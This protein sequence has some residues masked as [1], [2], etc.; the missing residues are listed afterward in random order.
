MTGTRFRASLTVAVILALHILPIEMLASNPLDQSAAARDQDDGWILDTSFGF[1]VRIALTS[2]YAITSLHNN[3]VM[4]V[5]I[6]DRYCSPDHLRTVF[7]SLATR[8]QDAQ[9]M[10]IDVYSDSEMLRR[11]IKRYEGPQDA[12]MTFPDTPEGVALEKKIRG[13]LY[14]PKTGWARARYFKGLRDG[15]GFFYKPDP[16]KVEMAEVVMK[17]KPVPKYAGEPQ[18]DLFL[19]CKLGDLLKVKTLIESGAK[20]DYKDQDGLTALVYAA[21]H[22]RPEIAKFL[23]K[24]GAYIDAK[25]K[26]GQTALCVAL[27]HGFHEV[28]SVLLSHNADVNARYGSGIAALHLASYKGDADAVEALLSKG[29]DPNAT[30]GDGNT[31]LFDAVRRRNARIVRAL[32]KNGAWVTVKN[33]RGQTLDGLARETGD[34]AI[35]ELI[36]TNKSR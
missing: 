16:Q 32:I 24:H 23:L 31:P 30:D 27:S 8:Y 35:I 15:E 33:N 25:N 4:F 18:A 19:A 13:D 28:V 22:D 1:P 21:G 7:E 5:L 9:S 12:D 14:I 36:G 6:E 11:A 20:V 3:L 29:A 2:S 34:P 10:E 26:Y 17:P